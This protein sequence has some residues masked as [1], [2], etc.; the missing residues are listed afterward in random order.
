MI[1]FR[2]PASL[3]Y[4]QNLIRHEEVIWEQTHTLLAEEQRTAVKFCSF[5]LNIYSQGLSS[6]TPH[7]EVN[8]TR[9]NNLVNYTANV[10]EL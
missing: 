9:H 2:Q 8:S 5:L 3:P 1:N 6:V 4:P 7:D 10:W